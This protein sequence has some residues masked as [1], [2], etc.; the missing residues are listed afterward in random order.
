MVQ[1]IALLAPV[2]LLGSGMSAGAVLHAGAGRIGRVQMPD[3]VSALPARQV[4]IEQGFSIRIA[5]SAPMMPPQMLLEL[6]RDGAPDGAF[7]AA[8]RRI[9]HC[10]PVNAIAGVRA[11]QHNR[12]LLFMRDDRIVSAALEKACSAADFY[13]GFYIDHSGDGLLCVNRD[14]LQ[15]RSGSNC[16]IRRLRL[17]SHS[18]RRG[19]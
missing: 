10:V 18:G 16:Q 3:P 9:G 2:A 7:T 1:L 4:R 5:P 15:S 13:S 12:L 6:E 17:L 11:G 19:L 8:D 14:R